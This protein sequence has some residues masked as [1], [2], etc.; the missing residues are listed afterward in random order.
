[1]KLWLI[2]WFVLSCIKQSFA[3]D[4]FQLAPPVMHFQSVFF[5]DTA[6]VSLLFAMKGSTIHYT[7]NGKEPTSKS[8]VYKHPI[9]IRQNFTT[10]KAKVFSDGFLPSARAEAV[11]IKEGL[12]IKNITTSP[13]HSKYS[14]EGFNTLHN[15]KGGI[16]SFGTK[17][18]L[19]FDTDTV[20]INITLTKKQNVKKILVHLLQDYGGWIFFPHR[21]EVFVPDAMQNNW[22]L[23][24]SKEITSLQNKDELVCKPF[25]LPLMKKAKTNNIQLLLYIVKQ[26][27]GWHPGK[28]QKSWIFIDEVKVY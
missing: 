13:P 10:V 18:W 4:T 17:T 9:L 20:T 5:T 8:P 24:A 11:F 26:I 21:I 19:G 25:L 1:M 16:A 14:E 15:N 27:P 12:P 22:H 6:T 3:Q 23:I 28:G 2:L 7:T